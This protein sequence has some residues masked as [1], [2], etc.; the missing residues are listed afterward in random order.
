MEVPEASFLIQSMAAFS[1]FARDGEPAEEAQLDPH[2]PAVLN[3]RSE[4]A[5]T[6]ERPLEEFENCRDLENGTSGQIVLRLPDLD[7]T[8]PV[9]LRLL[10]M[11]QLFWVAIVL[12][13]LLASVLI[14]GG[15]KVVPQEIDD[16]PVR[17]GQAPWRPP[18]A[19]DNSS[20]PDPAA[21]PEI[22]AARR[23]DT[24]RASDFAPAMPGVAT[25]VGT[26]ITG[27]PE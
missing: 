12:G 23:V 1:I 3:Y 16:V 8:Q 21:P 9:G 18:G 11:P 6:G 7:S 26:I 22:R 19:F 10:I 14:W 4:G 2:E 13:A 25:P 20:S 15:P 24:P 5:S 17:S 27:A